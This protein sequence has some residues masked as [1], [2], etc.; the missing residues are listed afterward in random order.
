[1]KKIS[2][3]FILFFSFITV[4]NADACDYKEE[5][6]LSL[7]SSN[8]SYKVDYSEANDNFVVTLYN[9]EDKIFAT[10][11]NRSYYQNN[12]EIVL[13]GIE[14]GAN[15]KVELKANS[16]YCLTKTLRAINISVPYVNRFYGRTECKGHEDLNICSS[17]FLP[18][19]MSESSFLS[20][21]R[22]MS[23]TLKD[24]ERIQYDEEETTLWQTIL[25][26]LAEIYIPLII[27][28]LSS[29]ITIFI[30]YPMYRKAKYGF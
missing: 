10:Y 5:N 28:V 22:N 19:K 13:Y 30:F 4:V 16:L 3:M 7:I 21:L 1:M 11:N 27:V 14:E 15:M 20:T 8:V 17:K 25:E 29:T 24:K 23:F 26:L 6:E 18:Y 9:V 2:I 12:K